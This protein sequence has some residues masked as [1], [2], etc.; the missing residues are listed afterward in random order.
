[1]NTLKIALLL[2][3][4]QIADPDGQE[5]LRELI[6]MLYVGQISSLDVSQ[7]RPA[8]ARLKTF[9]GR[10]SYPQ[11]LVDLYNFCISIFKKASG[12]RLYP[13]ECHDIMCK[14]EKL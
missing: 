14:I 8:G 2:L 4:L 7:V 6:A 3:Q 11:P 1:M 10:A 5:T 12:R 9:G 13:I